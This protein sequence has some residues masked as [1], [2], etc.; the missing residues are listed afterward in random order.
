MSVVYITNVGLRDLTLDGQIVQPARAK[1]EELLQQLTDLRR[2][3]RG[4]EL[5]AR[6]RAPI[7][8]AAMAYVVER[9]ARMAEALREVVLVASDQPADTEERHRQ[10]DTIFF[11]RL[12]E[13]LLRHREEQARQPS[14][15]DALAAAIRQARAGGVAPDPIR[16]TV[17][18]LEGNPADYDRANQFYGQRLGRPTAFA[19]EPTACFISVS[20]ATPAMN[21]GLLLKAVER[22]AE[23]CHPLY[24]PFGEQR[25]LPMDIGARL[26]R[27][28]RIREAHALVRSFAFGEARAILKGLEEVP[29]DVL[30]LCRSA[31]A[32]LGFDFGRAL[33]AAERG[34]QR[35]R[36]ISQTFW[37]QWRE[38]V[39][40]LYQGKDAARFA[41]AVHNAWV[42]WQRKEWADFLVRSVRLQEVALRSLTCTEL[43][44]PPDVNE[45]REG[46]SL[47][48]AA[49][50]NEP[51]RRWVEARAQEVEPSLQAL[52]WRRPSIP[53]R[54]A[55]AECLAERGEGLDG[56]AASPEQQDA[57]R[58][59]ARAARTWDAFR[60]LRNKTVH[61]LRGVSQEDISRILGDEEPWAALAALAAAGGEELGADRCGEPFRRARDELE[62]ALARL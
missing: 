57:W 21:T 14:S 5:L 19:E 12:I 18:R 50:R 47:E 36:M 16:Y 15:G 48:E 26:V 49:T 60:E 10:T 4:G 25:P 39:V 45:A 32:R 23:R 22:F 8:E 35:A 58:R 56:R 31:E 24:L 53:L 61:Y 55:I 34:L 54:L 59:L 9:A 1:G 20:G 40:A 52:T 33:D 42:A 13:Q 28:A 44:L 43:G 7:I 6:L 37:R 41:E 17:W 30:C 46:A 51:L 2:Q 62:G 27:G 29:D 3:G 11:A 38:E